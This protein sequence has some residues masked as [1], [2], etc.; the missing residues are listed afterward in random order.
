MTQVRIADEV[1]EMITDNG[2]DIQ[3]IHLNSFNC[4]NMSVLLQAFFNA[5]ISDEI[6]ENNNIEMSKWKNMSFD[7]I[8]QLW[9]KSIANQGEQDNDAKQFRSL[10]IFV[11]DFENVNKQTLINLILILKE[12][13]KNIP[14][15]FVFLLSN[16]L[17]SSIQYHL[18]SLATD[19]LQIEDIQPFYEPKFIPQ[20]LKELILDENIHFKIHPELVQEIYLYFTNYE[21]SFSHFLIFLKSLVFDYFY[22]NPLSV[23]CQNNDFPKLLQGNRHLLNVFKNSLPL[24]DEVDGDDSVYIQTIFDQ[25]TDLLKKHSEFVF[26]LQILIDLQTRCLC[27]PSGFLAL[28]CEMVNETECNFKDVFLSPLLKVK[29]NTWNSALKKV[30]SKCNGDAELVATLAQYQLKLADILEKELEDEKNQL[31]STIKLGLQCDVKIVKDKLRN[32]NSRSEWRQSM[33]PKVAGQMKQMSS[34]DQWKVDLIDAIE[35]ILQ[36]STPSQYHYL[37]DAIFYNNI[38]FVRSHHFVSVRDQLEHC[39]STSK[40]SLKNIYPNSFIMYQLYK[41]ASPVV[42]LYEWFEHFCQEKKLSKKGLPKSELIVH[43]S[44]TLSDFDYIGLLQSS[45]YKADYLN[46]LVWL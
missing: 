20:L 32:L 39:L 7:E 18:P 10:V 3:T 34:F 42:N 4:A 16:Q 15:I 30:I 31:N 25:Y 1:E 22:K 44:T 43:F 23:V 45:K 28:Y 37:L 13:M 36:H 26:N 46:K 41:E 29:E 2:N 21:L 12:Y 19:N 33:A 38:D 11:F 8:I 6:C 27:E 17:N 35:Q 14:I 24:S 40:R 9:R 5:L